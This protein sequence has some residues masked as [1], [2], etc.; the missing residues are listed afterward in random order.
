M[1]CRDCA[2]AHIGKSKGD[3]EMASHGYRSCAAARSSEEKGRYVKGET[4]CV[5]PGRNKAK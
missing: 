2:H 1:I 3:Q 4:E 5:Y